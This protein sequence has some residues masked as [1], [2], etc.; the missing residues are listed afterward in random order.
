MNLEICEK[1]IGERLG[2]L[3]RCSGKPNGRGFVG[4]S[5][6]LLC[7]IV[8]GGPVVQK[9]A[10]FPDEAVSTS[11]FDKPATNAGDFFVLDELTSYVFL[12]ELKDTLRHNVF[13]ADSSYIGGGYWTVCPYFLEHELYDW[14]IEK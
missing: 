12:N 6:V 13:K 14:N 10:V 11:F 9:C 2:I 5:T 1:C 3:V 4:V 7:N 8:V